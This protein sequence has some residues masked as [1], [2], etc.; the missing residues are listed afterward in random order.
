MPSQPRL[1]APRTLHEVFWCEV[2]LFLGM[3]TFAVTRLAVSEELP[4]GRKYLK[5][6]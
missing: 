4:A 2:R 1:D 5:A 6:L 3:T